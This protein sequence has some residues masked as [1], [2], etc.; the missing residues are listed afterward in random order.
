MVIIKTKDSIDGSTLYIYHA[1]TFTQFVTYINGIS[2]IPISSLS[3]KGDWLMVL[4][5]YVDVD[6][7]ICYEKDKNSIFI[8]GIK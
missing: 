4:A 7:F 3:L 2:S 1:D 5:E 8:R 6:T